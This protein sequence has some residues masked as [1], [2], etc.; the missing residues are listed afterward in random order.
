MAQRV[1]AIIFQNRGGGVASPRLTGRWPSRSTVV[2]SRHRSANLH[3]RFGPE[4]DIDRVPP[5]VR[6]G[7]VADI[8]EQCADV[9]YGSLADVIG[10]RA[11]VRFG[12]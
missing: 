4:A 7:P 11:L 1:A 6:F 12:S 3:V 10:Q 9:G 5:S 8:G 2:R